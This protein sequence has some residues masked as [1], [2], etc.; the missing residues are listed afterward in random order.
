[1]A[2]VGHST[3]STDDE[4]VFPI[5]WLHPVHGSERGAAPSSLSL[6][7]DAVNN[8]QALRWFANAAVE[9]YSHDYSRL[10]LHSMVAHKVMPSQ[11][12]ER[13]LLIRDISATEGTEVLR[14][15][16]LFAEIVACSFA[17]YPGSD[18]TSHMIV[19]GRR[20]ASE[21]LP[22]AE[23]VYDARAS[24]RECWI[25][26]VDSGDP[27]SV[28]CIL[29]SL[30]SL[31]AI[32]SDLHSAYDVATKAL[33]SGGCSSVHLA[34]LKTGVEGGSEDGAFAE[35]KVKVAA[36]ILTAEN[37]QRDISSMAAAESFLLLSAQRHPNIVGFY[38]MFI[39][40]SPN[41]GPLQY[42]LN[43]EF[44]TGGDLHDELSARGPCSECQAAEIIFGVLSALAHV[45]SRGLLHR[46]VKAENIL[47]SAKSRPVL[48]DFGIACRIDDAQ[49]MQRRCGSP[50]YAAPEV[51]SGSVYD[52]K[53]DVFS[54]GALLYFTLSGTLPF[55]GPDISSVLR[56]TLRC[57]VKFDSSRLSSISTQMKTTITL[58]LQKDACQRVS[59]QAA[60][61]HAWSIYAVY[62]QEHA[63]WLGCNPPTPSDVVLAAWQESR[64]RSDPDIV[65]TRSSLGSKRSKG[66]RSISAI[67]TAPPSERLTADVDFVERETWE[68]SPDKSDC[69]LWSPI[70]TKANVLKDASQPGE[71]NPIMMNSAPEHV[72]QVG[73]EEQSKAC[74]QK[75]VSEHEVTRTRRRPEKIQTEK[76]DR[77]AERKNSP[78]V[79]HPPPIPANRTSCY[80]FQAGLREDDPEHS[81]GSS[82]GESPANNMR[83]RFFRPLCGASNSKPMGEEIQDTGVTA[84]EA[85]PTNED[86]GWESWSSELSR[87]STL[88][89]R[90]SFHRNSRH[91]YCDDD[92]VKGRPSQTSNCDLLDEPILEEMPVTTFR[93]SE[94]L[95]EMQD[96]GFKDDSDLMLQEY[97]P[98]Q[99]SSQRQQQ[100]LLRK[101]GSA[102]STYTRGMLRKGR[103]RSLNSNSTTS[104]SSSPSSST[105]TS[106]YARQA[107]NRFTTSC[108]EASKSSDE[109]DEPQRKTTSGII[110]QGNV[111]LEAAHTTTSQI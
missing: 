61:Q 101:W 110:S 27:I 70:S 75:S 2:A 36:K 18:E 25:I 38:G 67:S 40:P 86:R 29:T 96:E 3:T 80:M 79:P 71:R 12:G 83:R 105:N 46:D 33:G 65:D 72:L 76:V 90:S 47:L 95:E 108:Q 30:G 17:Q 26:I 23:S 109:Q 98:E 107:V 14:V 54:A 43:L 49:E 77:P 64:R 82:K 63:A 84:D 78:L 106:A 102:A 57:Q 28:G 100:L 60:L 55:S 88:S 74:Q 35:M 44:C 56:R 42:V 73:S 4:L 87:D 52:E 62:L 32:R 51:L 111:D 92:D 6:Q 94:I 39:N 93:E 9:E 16:L 66:D 24:F 31:G 69:M 89:C 97:N 85:W 58:L 34:S 37:S 41:G 7:E 103:S 1:M 21:N 15:P 11:Q 99:R 104:S 5:L 45:H 91:S 13:Q 48:S 22:G 19:L 81:R 53:I 10:Q 50:G 20:Q 8:V 59:A 68:N